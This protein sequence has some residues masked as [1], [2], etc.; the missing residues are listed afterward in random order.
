MLKHVLC[1]LQDASDSNK[2]AAQLTGSLNS[3][4]SKERQENQS[5]ARYSKGI[6]SN[7]DINRLIEA[8]TVD[9]SKGVQ[10]DENGSRNR[11]V[12]SSGGGV[13][14]DKYIYNIKAE[15]YNILADMSE[16]TQLAAMF[17]LGAG[18][19]SRKKTKRKK[20]EVEVVLPTPN[21]C[22]SCAYKNHKLI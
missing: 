6:R 12:V 15:E 13:N 4:S 19:K 8:P 7:G 10:E 21:V 1:C 5:G 22:L 11:N 18:R 17:A 3:E 14:G 9:F 16:F 2:T 20:E